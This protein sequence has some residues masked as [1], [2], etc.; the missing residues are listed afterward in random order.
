[1]PTSSAPPETLSLD[2]LATPI[3]TALLVTDERAALLAFNWTD[4]EPAMLSWIGRH[5]PMATLE[6]RRAPAALRG[7]FEAYFEGDA[8]AL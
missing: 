3:G 2:R 7:P 4:Y 1:M 8:R 6:E 5:Y